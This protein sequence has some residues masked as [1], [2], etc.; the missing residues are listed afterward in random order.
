M[1]HV[2]Q[3]VAPQIL[4]QSSAAAA[5]AQ[6]TESSGGSSESEW[7]TDTDN[8]DADGQELLKPVFV[9]KKAR[10]TLKR[11]EAEAAEEE[12]KRQLEAVRLEARKLETR[13]LVAEEI[14]REQEESARGGTSGDLT[15][16]EMPDDTDG[17]DPDQEYRDWELRE[18]RR[19]KR[20]VWVW[21]P[22]ATGGR[23]AGSCGEC[24]GVCVGMRTHR[25]SSAAGEWCSDRDR[26][27]QKRLEAEEVL[28]RRNMTAEEREA[29]DRC[30]CVVVASRQ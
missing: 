15:D 26:K 8:S 1:L 12:R 14:R 6:G 22:L 9:P 16:V 13:K 29:E 7:E 25:S 11:Q 23:L 27:E 18:M 5:A 28:R 19:I 10:E 30:A 20:Y 2:E 24:A 3:P 21:V 4:K 17:V